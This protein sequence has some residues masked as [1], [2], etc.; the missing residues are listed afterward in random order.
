MSLQDEVRT[1]SRSTH[2]GQTLLNIT[3]PGGYEYQEGE[4]SVFNG[5]GIKKSIFKQAIDCMGYGEISDSQKRN[6]IC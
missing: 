3:E 2:W 6:S 4:E 5:D 1:A